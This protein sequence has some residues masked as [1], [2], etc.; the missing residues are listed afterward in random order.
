MYVDISTNLF[1]DWF[2]ELDL[3]LDSL[4][5]I[6][7]VDMLKSD[8]IQVLNIIT[9]Q[10][11]QCAYNTDLR[12]DNPTRNNKDPFFVQPNS[13]IITF[14]RNFLNE[15]VNLGIFLNYYVNLFFYSM[16]FY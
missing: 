3:F 5:S 12:N 4:S 7:G 16:Y 14:Q 2:Q 13:P 15:Y 11:I 8:V 10:R 6:L 1:M 9:I